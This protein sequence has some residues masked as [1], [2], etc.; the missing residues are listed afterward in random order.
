MKSGSIYYASDK[1]LF[2]ALNQHKVTHSDLQDLFFSRGIIVSKDTERKQLAESFSRLTHD[3]YDHQKLASILGSISR[4]ERNTI[5]T[6]DTELDFSDIEEAA[7]QIKNDLGNFGDQ[8]DV[9]RKGDQI[10][11]KINY[12]E[13][14]YNKSEF[15]Q[16]VQK[17]ASIIFEKNDT[18][19]SIRSP[20]NDHIREVKS[21]ILDRIEVNRAIKLDINEIDLSHILSNDKRT[22]FFTDL[23]KSIKGY[24]VTDV[25]DV[26]VFHPKLEV[27]SDSE[28]DTDRLSNDIHISKASLKGEG[29]LQSEEI[30]SLYDKGF[31]I[32]K[33]VWRAGDNAPDSDSYE[34][35]VQFADAENCKQFTYL[36]KGFYKYKSVGEHNKNRTLPSNADENKFNKLIEN[37]AQASFQNLI[38]IEDGDT[39][40]DD[41]ENKVV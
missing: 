35:E 23:I 20:Q 27:S 25:T 9:Y 3:Y 39:N 11:I 36:Y 32:C 26:F 28:E 18:T 4:R 6:V 10:E 21:Q 17:D 38:K 31:Y 16:V 30:K 24:S 5:T 33:I 34:F 22:K 19:W 40:H 14:N 41:V 29:V 15:R 2:D 1:A 12:K 37:S 8:V 7:Q 13:T